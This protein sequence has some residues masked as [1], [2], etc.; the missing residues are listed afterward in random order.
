MA[1]KSIHQNHRQRIRNEIL[2]HSMD[3][4]EDYKILEVFL[5]TCLARGDTNE[6]AHRIIEHFGSIDMLMEA[7]GDELMRI[8]GVGEQT[9]VQIITA[10]ELFRRCLRA[11]LTHLN[12]S[13]NVYDTVQKIAERMWTYFQG[14]ARERL[15]V[16]LF[17]NRMSLISQR[18]ISNGTP[19]S[20]DLDGYSIVEWIV[21]KKGTNV[22]LVHNHPH[23][24]AHASPE[25]IRITN[26]MATILKYM[27][28]YLREHIIIADD[29]FST[30]MRMQNRSLSVT[31]DGTLH[32]GGFDWD[33]FYNVEENTYRFSTSMGL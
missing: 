21:R 18:I 8:D 13:D 33:H 3:H 11:R 5:Y 30:I 24:N 14:L 27:G 32:D 23:G 2:N 15:Y 31:R 9:A 4:M 6:L 22:V 7:N 28:I 25:D 19:H 12:A 16:L 1:P 26:E 20:T 17:D 29:Q 10:M